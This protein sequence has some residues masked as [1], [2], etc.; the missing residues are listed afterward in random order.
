MA[1]YRP[2]FKDPKTGKLRHSAVWWY[3]F[4]FDGRRIRE[5]AKTTRKTI[6]IEAEKK[7]RLEMERGYNDVPEKRSARIRTIKEIADTFLANYKVRNP[8][9]TTFATA[10]LG[11][12]TRLLGSRMTIDITPSVVGEFQ[13]A[14][15]KEKAAPK[16][17]N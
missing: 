1:V 12:V 2:K 11:H 15:L 14:R 5:S 10:A 8:R 6:A 13:T 9:S 3:E 17:I 16:T 4:N 7:R